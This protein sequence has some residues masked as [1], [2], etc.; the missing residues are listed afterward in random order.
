MKYIQIESA[1]FRK[2][3]FIWYFFLILLNYNFNLIFIFK[4]YWLSNYIKPIFDILQA[5]TRFHF[6]TN[7]LPMQFYSMYKPHTKL[8][9]RNIEFFNKSQ[10]WYYRVT[11]E[12][13]FPNYFEKEGKIL[14]FLCEKGICPFWPIF[15]LITFFFLGIVL[16]PFGQVYY[17]TH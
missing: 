14:N 1:N 5:I 8:D 11:K 17:H 12:G 6:Y 10:L 7:S 9:Y 16:P 4:K 13:Y 15:L 2:K 3:K